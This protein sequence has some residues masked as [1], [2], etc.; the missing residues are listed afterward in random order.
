MLI[1]LI[2]VFFGAM[3]LLG[4][5]LFG[6]IVAAVALLPLCFA[7]CS[8]T[9]AQI[10]DWAI[11]G[12]NYSAGIP[13]ILFIVGGA[14]M[15]K[16]KLTQKIFDIFN[17]FF[18]NK[19]GFMPIISILTAMFYSSISG[20]ATAVAAAVGGM[21]L[22]LLVEMG[23]DAAFC[24]VIL[25]CA[26]VLGFLIP[27]STPLTAGGALLGLD[28]IPLYSGGTMIGLIIGAALII[29]SYLYCR[30]HGNGNAEV[31]LKHH[32]EVKDR[33]FAAVF[34]D[35]IWALL[36][37]VIILGGIFSGIF[38][39]AQAAV[40]SVI[41]GAL[42]CVFVYKTLTW[43]ECMEAIRDAIKQ[44]LPMVVILMC[45]LILSSCMTQLGAATAIANA[46]SNMGLGVSAVIILILVALTILGM[47]MD[48][49]AAMAMLSP[50]VVPVATAMGANPYALFVGI[51]AVQS[52]GLIT[53]P[54]GL[55]LFMFLPMTKLPLSKIVKQLIVPFVIFMAIA[56]IFALV[57]GLSAWLY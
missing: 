22:P 52:M 41:Y 30:K 26:G 20:S 19:V 51:V 47:F 35:G 40:V 18:G 1:V 50:I 53:P 45:A 56:F 10:A 57:P 3:L 5:P 48:S 6:A 24:A 36:S 15:S 12:A 42:V 29:Y 7:D 16:G 46:I 43:K 37:P 55:V 44:S 21:C 25:M 8:F 33:G 38:T 39:V 9:F 2:A 49:G 4:V 23:Y 17:Y 11:S 31:I 14:L 32:K 54:F 13:I 27:P 28:V 34:K